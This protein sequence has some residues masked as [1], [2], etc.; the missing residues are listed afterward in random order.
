MMSSG[1]AIRRSASLAFLGVL[2]TGC[3]HYQPAPVSLDR[4]PA[5]LD[6]R[7]LE[8]PP[9]GGAW[10]EADLVATA[11]DRAPGVLEAA[12]AY[13]SAKAAARTAR[14]PPSAL[15]NLTAEY[16][17]D[18]GGTSPW[19]FGYTSEIPLDIGGRRK[20]RLTTADL[21]ALQAQ[22]D[23]GEAVWSVRMA[24]RKAVIDRAFSDREIALAD[25]LLQVRRDRSAKLGLRLRA[26]EDARPTALTAQVEL[27]A[28][29]RRLADAGARR[30]QADVALA[31]AM[32]LSPAALA[33]LNIDPIG[34]APAVPAAADIA[35]WRTQA[36]LSRRDVLRA[37]A[38][39][40]QA[41]A[42]LRLEIAKQY[43]EVHVGPGYTWER[44]VTKLPFTLYLV[45]PPYDLNRA[46]IREAEARRLQA[47]KTLESVQ[48]SALAAVDQANA[49]LA[50]AMAGLDLSQRQDLPLALRTESAAL[51]SLEAGEIDKVDADAARAAVLDAELTALEAAR[52]AWAALADLEDALRRPF[53]TAETAVLQ[54]AI[55][56][57]GNPA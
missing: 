16:S 20:S 7:R 25:R 12:A 10:T 8:P 35:S 28:A 5:A 34:A 11:L 50:A 24:V 18:A 56:R 33:A 29:E 44:G 39:Y 23:Y 57:L 19:L 26:G 15:L 4:Y 49:A 6:S 55:Q 27:A 43:P 47:G 48:A 36:A 21:T 52:L 2:I 32:G 41:E 53:D 46:A 42:A 3:V 45:L 31:K 13:R 17:K 51:R 40:D 1:P 37:V 22:Y 54:S 30:A 9:G 14:V 38:G